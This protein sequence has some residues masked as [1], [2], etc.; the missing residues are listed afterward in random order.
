MACQ[1]PTT[2]STAAEEAVPPG[3]E[4]TPAPARDVTLPNPKTSGLSHKNSPEVTK[5][6]SPGIE[7]SSVP[8]KPGKLSR[9]Q[10]DT[11]MR[12][13]SPHTLSP[14]QLDKS[15]CWTRP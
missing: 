9:L 6:E 3:T 14:K 11:L 5:T 8:A 7:T 10:F 4:T 1:A 12:E 2:M 15:K 13:S